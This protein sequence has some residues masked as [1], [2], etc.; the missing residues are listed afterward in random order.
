M[1]KIIDTVLKLTALLVFTYGAWMVFGNPIIGLIHDAYRIN[2]II[3]NFRNRWKKK[4]QNPVIEHLNLILSVVLKR[5]AVHEAYIFIPASVIIFLLSFIFIIKLESFLS[6]LIFSLLLALLP[7]LM[8]RAMLRG[9][10]IEGSYDGVMLVTGLTNNYKQSYCNMLEAVDKTACSQNLS[11]FSKTNLLRL[12][13]K[14]KSYRNEAELDEAV[15]TFVYAYD[16]EWSILLG[17]NIKIAVKDGINIITSLDDILLEL[18][19]AG[20]SIEANKRFNNESFSM[21]K[22]VLLPLY[23]LTVYL[24][25]SAF[26]FTLEKYIKYQFSTEL[27]LKSA[28]IMFSSI[29]A[30]FIILI[31]AQKPKYDI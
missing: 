27:G 1:F 22:F 15:K 26:G 24:S 25:T 10:R 9:I 13:I 5:E 6:A 30:C 14:L 3:R 18:K 20:E 29:I 12:S 28:I 23:L 21:I 2:M 11:H 8:I 17:M 7:Y 4:S 16:T 19:N 31:L